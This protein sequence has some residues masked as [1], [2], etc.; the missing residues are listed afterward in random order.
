MTAAPRR[1]LLTNS[2]SLY[3][4]GEFYVLELSAALLSRG[5]R[6]L[7]ACPPGNLLT[8]KCAAAGVPTVP[9]C[10]P[11]NGALPKYV[12]ILRSLIREHGISVVHTNTNYDRTA[13][14]FA[15]KLERAAHV[16]N[17]HSFH[18]ISHNL[19]HMVRNR[20]ATDH[21]LVDGVCVKDL[22]VREDRIAPAK[23]SV[24]H[25]GVD[26][27]AMRR[28]GAKRAAVRAEFGCAAGDVVVG[29]V[30]RLVPFKG[31]EYLLRAFALS[32]RAHPSA[33]LL[34]VGDGELREALGR[35]AAELGIGHRV[36]FA[37]FRDDLVAVYS[38]FD[39]YCH[40]SV[41]GGGET[42]P[43]A[44]LQ[45]LSQE[46]PVVVTR[47]GDVGEM[48]EEGSNGFALPDR[49]PEAIA[50]ALDGLLAQPAMAAAMGAR[51][52]ALLLRRFTT[53]RM[54]DAVEEV[55]GRLS[56]LLPH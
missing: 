37:G 7:V 48:V 42:F 39:V 47:V 36:A 1:I 19:T 21:F 16:T 52:R 30:G 28:D 3:A 50:R 41:E 56:P 25:L 51:S 10:F 40:A 5:R 6:V 18:S 14:A 4:G 13:G 24:V 22:L 53:D 31:Q 12:G 45:A 11:A 29:N 54:V 15:A 43:F 27:D 8:E 35:L 17:V 34:L 32:Y 23:I 20:W 38:A 26:P 46:L 2:S 9:V 44:V 33:K 55:Y 49:D